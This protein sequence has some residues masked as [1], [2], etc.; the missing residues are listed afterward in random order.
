MRQI[1]IV[2]SASILLAGNAQAK[3]CRHHKH[4][5]SS[6]P[7][8][9]ITPSYLVADESGAIIKKQD[10]KLVRPIASISKLMLALLSSEQDLNEQLQ[11]PGIR[12][13][14]TTIPHQIKTLTRK[15]LLTLTLVHSD[16]FAA[17]ILCANLPNCVDKMNEKAAELGM[18][19]VMAIRVFAG[20]LV[21][22][23]G[24]HAAVQASA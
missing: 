9:F 3:I 5:E 6:N 22:I 10:D 11:I 19:P 21:A 13:V 12:Q 8:A 24:L 14:Q 20:A 18:V 15:E 1:L 4:I 2:L 7:P 23:L 17:Q 16:N